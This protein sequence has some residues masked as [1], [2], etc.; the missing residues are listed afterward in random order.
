[1]I[2]DL[3]M[4]TANNVR[5]RNSHKRTWNGL[6]HVLFACVSHRDA[7][8]TPLC[9]V[10]TSLDQW[11]ND[12]FTK[13]SRVWRNGRF[14][15]ENPAT[16]QLAVDGA[17]IKARFGSLPEIDV[18]GAPIKKTFDSLPE[19]DDLN[20]LNRA[21][22][23]EP[24]YPAPLP[25]QFGFLCSN[26]VGRP[27]AGRPRLGKPNQEDHKMYQEM[28]RCWKCRYMHHYNV[29]AESAPNGN[30]ERESPTQTAVFCNEPF[31]CAEDLVQSQCA[32]L[33]SREGQQA[34]P[35]QPETDIS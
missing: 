13:V 16:A 33:R 17:R 7:A 9:V 5:P 35:K 15:K 19:S 27:F 23:R 10:G 31:S 6:P 18:D 20:R 24:Q 12:F 8:G 14:P 34:I 2:Q 11:S 29:N 32:R 28:C 26:E 25:Q 21:M 30:L 4:C 3:S 1:M 22:F